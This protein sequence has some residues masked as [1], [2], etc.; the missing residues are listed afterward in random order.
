MGT[1]LLLVKKQQKF[2][3]LISGF[4]S[5][6]YSSAKKHILEKIADKQKAV[7]KKAFFVSHRDCF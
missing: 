1:A 6:K 2:C 5:P 7:P 4:T 3:L